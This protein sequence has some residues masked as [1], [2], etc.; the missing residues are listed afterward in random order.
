MTAS[1]PTTLLTNADMALYRAKSEGRNVYRFFEPGMDAM[2]RARRALET[3]LER[4]WPRQR[5]RAAI[6]SRS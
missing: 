1:T 6:S 4:R 5:V 3:D 2:V